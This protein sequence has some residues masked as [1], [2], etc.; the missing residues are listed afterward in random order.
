M[1]FHRK[2]V[3]LDVPLK[4]KEKKKIV[5]SLFRVVS[6]VFVLV[7]F[8]C[9]CVCVSRAHVQRVVIFYADCLKL[10]TGYYCT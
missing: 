9:A 5:F 1:I 7:F 4:T 2:L 3:L 8:C 10:E 6:F